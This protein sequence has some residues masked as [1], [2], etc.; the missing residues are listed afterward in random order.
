MEAMRK[1]NQHTI[2]VDVLPTKQPLFKFLYKSDF[3]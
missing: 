2:D 1:K 3:T